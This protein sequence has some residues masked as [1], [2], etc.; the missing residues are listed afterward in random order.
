M[1][2]LELR[3]LRREKWRIDGEPIRTIEEAREFV[4]SVGMCLIY[5]LRPMP[6]LPTLIGAIAGTD[7]K[8]PTRKTELN[9]PRGIETEELL[10]RLARE[11]SVYEARLQGETLVLSAQLFP[12]FYALA[13]D[14]K[15]KQ[16]IV[17]RARGKASPLSEHLFRKLQEQGPLSRAQLQQK[18][19][20]ALS[21]A[22]LDGALQ[23]LW[24]EV[25]VTRVDHRSA[26]GDSWD[27]YY[28]WAP[29]AVN[30]GVRLSDAEA[31]S[32]VISKYLD[33]VVAATQDEI[34]TFFSAIT[35]RTRVG[36]VVRS[37][38]SAREFTYTP[39]ETRTLITVAHS[40]AR[41]E[42]SRAQIGGRRVTP[43][44]RRRNG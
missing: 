22:A 14:R 3:H 19:G 23:E 12:Y 4:D 10:A 13:S 44:R 41:P 34:E 2:E 40:I 28:R 33:C 16:P 5:P 21:E 42:S 27:V 25:K 7:Q 17:S 29:E 24:T 38:L 31:L 35:S 43:A 20:G 36:E 8:L 32:A 6:L 39:S 26:G 18:L 1:T 37:L 11:K 30:E 9:D 15:P